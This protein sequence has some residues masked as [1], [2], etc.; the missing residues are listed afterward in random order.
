MTDSENESTE[1]DS[2]MTFDDYI[3]KELPEHLQRLIMENLKGSTTN[4]LKQTSNNSEFNVS[5]NRSFKVSMM[6]FKLCKCKACC[7]L[8][9]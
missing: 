2:L 6:Q 3:S 1:T 4:D 9:R 5:K 8:L 7:I